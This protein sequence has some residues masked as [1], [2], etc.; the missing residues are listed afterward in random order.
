MKVSIDAK[1]RG[2]PMVMIEMRARKRACGNEVEA[3][4]RWLVIAIERPF[5]NDSVEYFLI[6]VR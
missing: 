1:K 3:G 2:I 6:S 4:A 5:L